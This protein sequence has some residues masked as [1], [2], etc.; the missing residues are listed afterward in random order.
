[1]AVVFEAYKAGKKIDL[2][3][4]VIP[5][6]GEYET[7]GT[8]QYAVEIADLDYLLLGGGKKA[9]CRMRIA[10]KLADGSTSAFEKDIPKSVI[11]LSDCSQFSFTERAATGEDAPILWFKTGHDLPL[12]LVT[13]EDVIAKAANEGSVLIL[14]LRFNS[15]SGAKRKTAHRQPGPLPIGPAGGPR[16]GRCRLALRPRLAAEE[17]E[18]RTPVRDQQE[19]D[20]GE[21]TDAEGARDEDGAVAAREL[22]DYE[23]NRQQ[24]RFERREPGRTGSLQHGAHYGIRLVRPVRCQQENR[25]QEVE[26]SKQRKRSSLRQYGSAV[27]RRFGHGPSFDA[28]LPAPSAQRLT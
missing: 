7:N 5:D 4:S 6:L 15:G 23:R 10:F 9:T 26:A 18:Q 20:V 21:D 11:D 8:I 19:E 3:D 12:N 17:G 14:T 24:Q 22:R 16:R 2:P 13:R 27:W 25:G 1:M 28:A